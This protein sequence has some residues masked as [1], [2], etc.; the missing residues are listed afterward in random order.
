M[1][2]LIGNNSV[3]ERAA[4]RGFR[5]P[6]MIETSIAPG[7][8]HAGGLLPPAVGALGPAGFFGEVCEI[9]VAVAL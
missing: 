6:S 1:S 4:V 9:E 3:N 5:V 8:S 2:L 7:D